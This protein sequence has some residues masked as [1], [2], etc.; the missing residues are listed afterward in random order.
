MGWEWDGDR[1]E[2]KG[3]RP[4]LTGGSAMGHQQEKVT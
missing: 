2:K 4:N 3:E 1:L